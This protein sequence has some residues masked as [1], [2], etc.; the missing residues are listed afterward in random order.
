MKLE[1]YFPTL[2]SLEEQRKLDIISN[3]VANSNSPGFKKDSVNFS[4]VLGDVFFTSMS[5]GPIRQTGEKLDIAL[6]GDGFL[7]VQTDQGT[8]YTR[9]GNLT[10]NKSNQLVTTDGWPVL[11]K[12]GPIVVADVGNFRVNDDGQVFDGDNKVDQLKIA[13]FPPKTLQKSQNG[14][15]QPQTTDIQPGTATNCTVRQGALESPNFNPVE[16]MTRVVTA[17]RNFESYQ[18][19]ITNNG[20]LDSELISKTSG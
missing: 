19:M 14:Y 16:E 6:S 20:N 3:N 1:A 13:Q 11:G 7:T 17:M 15:F 2:G 5:Q 4:S 8:L 12:N 9:A 18:K 10:I